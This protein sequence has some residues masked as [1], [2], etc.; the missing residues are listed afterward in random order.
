MTRTDEHRA[1]A[2]VVDDALDGALGGRLHL[3]VREG[4]AVN[5]VLKVPPSNPLRTS[6]STRLA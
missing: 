1:Q 5:N 3:E 4:V 6:H 2:C